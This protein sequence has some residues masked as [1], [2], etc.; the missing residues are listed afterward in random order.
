M[1]KLPFMQFYPADWLQDTRILSPQAKGAWIDLLCAAW[2]APERGQL[3]WSYDHVQHFLG[4]T[5]EEV[6][7]ILLELDESNVGIVERDNVKRCVT[8]KCRRMIKEE[9]KRKQVFERV[10]RFRNANVTET[11]RPIYQKS[12]VRSHISDKDK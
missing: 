1:S 4:V 9:D 7:N 6:D 3:Y 11:K 5:S 2:I 10:K 8:I 12:E